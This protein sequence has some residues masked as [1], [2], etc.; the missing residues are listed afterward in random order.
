MNPM[1]ICK[2]EEI[3]SGSSMYYPI[4]DKAI[5]AVYL[6]LQSGC[7]SKVWIVSDKIPMISS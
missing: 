1:I 7:W 6:Y 5:T 4:C 3:F 2:I